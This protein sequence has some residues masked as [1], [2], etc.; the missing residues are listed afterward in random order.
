MVVFCVWVLGYPLW[1]GKHLFLKMSYCLRHRQ[2][3]YFWA[4]DTRVHPRKYGNFLDV[5]KVR[6]VKHTPFYLAVTGESAARCRNLAALVA[7]W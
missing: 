1:V 5:E 6:R 3:L 2:P 4:F 7:R